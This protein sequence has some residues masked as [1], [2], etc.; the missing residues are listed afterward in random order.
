MPDLR[1]SQEEADTKLLLHADHAAKSR[2]KAVVIIAEDT[3]VF[4]M[5]L[6]FSNKL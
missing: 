6:A 1:S 5:C 2:C 3:D 4:V